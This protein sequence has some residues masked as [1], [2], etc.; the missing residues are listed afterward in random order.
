MAKFEELSTAERELL[1]GAIDFGISSAERRCKSDG[2]VV[3]KAAH[4][5]DADNLR[6]LR[7]KLVLTK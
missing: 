6:A 7:A 1:L 4:K 5:A 2:S 3:V